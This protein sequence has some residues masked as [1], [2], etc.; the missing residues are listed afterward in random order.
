MAVA[1]PFTPAHV[2]SLAARAAELERLGEEAQDPHAFMRAARLYKLAIRIADDIDQ[3]KANTFTHV[4]LVRVRDELRTLATHS[5]AASILADRGAPRHAAGEP[6]DAV[7]QVFREVAARLAQRLA[8][9]AVPPR[10]GPDA[11]ARA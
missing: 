3:P 4:D 1:W 2:S 8:G 10:L 5:A 6:N 11:E 9:D 7:T